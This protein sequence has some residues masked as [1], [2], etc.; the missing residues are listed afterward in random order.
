[1]KQEEYRSSDH[2][3]FH[4]DKEERIQSLSPHIR[5]RSSEKLGLFKRNRSLFII[6]IDVLIIV[7][8]IVVVLPFVGGKEHTTVIE[9]YTFTLSGFIFEDSSLF[10]LHIL[11]EKESASTSNDNRVI[12]VT[13]SIEGTEEQRKVTDLLPVS[14]KERIIRGRIPYNGAGKQA[15]ALIRFDQ[16]EF[17]L[18]TTLSN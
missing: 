17:T 7:L 9:G 15:T 12:T 5:D 18:T 16:T 4:Y 10:N 14:Q 2:L 6:L 13:F 3:H 11:S 1:M 8:I